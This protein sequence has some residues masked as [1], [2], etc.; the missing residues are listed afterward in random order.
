MAAKIHLGIK[1]ANKSMQAVSLFTKAGDQVTNVN[2]RNLRAA[3]ET[4]VAAKVNK[5]ISALKLHPAEMKLIQVIRAI[6]FGEIEG[7]RIEDGLPAYYKGAKKT[8]KLA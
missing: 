2:V 3:S 5:D 6:E 7:L 8:C 4:S 1:I